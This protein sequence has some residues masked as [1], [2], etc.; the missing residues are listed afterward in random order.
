MIGIYKITNKLN[1]KIY[2]GQSN[3]IQRRF[4]EHQ[5]KGSDSRIPVDVAIE[6]YGYQ[7][8]SYEVVEEC[9]TEQLNERET[10]WITY[11]NSVE[12]GYNCSLGGNQQSTGENNGR[13]KLT[14]DDVRIIRTAYN[15]HK[16]RKE[17][18]KQFKDK[19]AFSTFANV[20]DGHTWNHIMP[21]VFTEENKQYYM[22]HATDG[23]NSDFATL[24]DEEVIEC[25]TRYINETARE[26]HRQFED[27]ISY[28]AFQ[29]M[30]WG[31]TY[32][33]LPV[34]SKKKK[35]WVNK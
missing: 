18:Y 23:G 33:N 3:N 32:K 2:I 30:L 4:V 24:T 5:G 8:F 34:Y 16:R 21:E 25:R 13:A 28:Q 17:V 11:Y 35:E 20:W 19:I 7:N 10:Y 9:L 14:E 31:R 22:Y 6:K 29:A 1:G 27:R 15:N 26:I 12:N